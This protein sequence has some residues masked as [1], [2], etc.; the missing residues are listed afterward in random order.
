MDVASIPSSSR[1]APAKR[2][3]L[4]C[5]PCRTAHIKCNAKKPCD[6]CSLESKEC[7]YA[8]SRRGGLDR[9]T[10]AAR[11]NLAAAIPI[12]FTSLEPLPPAVPTLV[13]AEESSV[14]QDWLGRE[15][16]S[17]S[18]ESTQSQT[19]DSSATREWG[20]Q[21]LEF[22]ASSSVSLAKDLLVDLYYRHFHKL[23][24]LA[25]P[26]PHLERLMTTGTTKLDFRP[27]LAVMRFIGSLYSHSVSS[28]VLKA[29]ATNIVF[30]QSTHSPNS[31]ILAQCYL[32]QS[33]SLHW[34]DELGRA[35]ETMDAAI[36]VALQLSMNKAAFAAD[37]GE[38]DPVIQESWRRT[39][40]QIYIID[41]H[42]AAIRHAMTFPT[43]EVDI[44]TELPCDED[45]Y[46]SGVRH[47]EHICHSEE[48]NMLDGLLTFL[49]SM[50]L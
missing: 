39:W 11:R 8:K 10:L 40:W 32:L 50:L 35:R 5:V 9:A 14:R 30:E 16:V 26:L 43:N 36:R 22:L 46:E 23:H 3:S 25:I 47:L 42:Y 33:I 13:A 20:A 17:T 45:E 19:R 38:G 44:T 1:K 2:V 21:H 18:T 34:C 15:N 27:L 31:P 24:P 12:P 7:F 49:C 41:G 29:D 48:L 4:A 6:R 28:D 37:H